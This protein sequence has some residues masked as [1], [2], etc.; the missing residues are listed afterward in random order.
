MIGAYYQAYKKPNC[1]EFV[2]KNYRKHYPDTDL[3]LVSDGGDDFSDLAKQYNCI[4]FYEDNLSG[5][6]SDKSKGLASSYFHNENI[7]LNYAL[8]FGKYIQ[9]IKNQQFMILEDDVYVINNTSILPYD[10]NGINL[11][12]SLPEPVCMDLKNVKR[13]PYGACGGCIFNTDFFKNIFSESNL[14]NITNQV[15]KYCSLTNEKWASDAII[16]YLCFANNGTS[17]VWN[18]L[19]ETWQTNLVDRINKGEIDVIH[20]Y[21]VYY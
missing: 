7:L 6:Y 18:G 11:T 5:P 8:R 19:G 21:K 9:K 4:Y 14:E 10:L 15:K 13:I 3:V 17:G 16:S 12:E 1:V 20:Q 2:L